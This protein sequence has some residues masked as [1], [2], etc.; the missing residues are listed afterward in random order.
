MTR[1]RIL[2]LLPD[3]NG[4]GAERMMLYLV[5]GLDRSRYE[6][7][8][9][10]GLKRGPYL[11]MVPDDIDFIELGHERG[12]S[13]IGSI[14][15]LFR[16]GGYDLCFSMVSM[17]PAAV[18]ARELSRSRVRLVLGARNHYSSSLPAEA[19]ASRL[20]MLAIRMLYPRAD[21]VIGVSQGVAD[22]LVQNFGVPRS[23]VLAIH[24][25]VDLDR[26][27]ALA[28]EPLD[29]P[30]FAPGARVP[31]LVAVGKLQPAKGYPDLLAAFRRVRDTMPVRLVILG[32]GPDRTQI[33]SIVDRT[34]LRADVRLVGFDVNPY[35]WLSRAA[36]FVHA[37]HWEGFPNVLVEAMA[38][39]TP[40]V[41]TDCPSGPA[42]ILTDGENGFLVPVGDMAAHAARTLAL[43]SDPALRARIRAAADRRVEDFAVARV[44]A[45]YART[46]DDV[47][48]GRPSEPAP[49]TRG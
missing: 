13:S 48:G 36:V 15:R 40:V 34:G 46:F 47:I 9:A 45:R 35:R 38:C 4:G 44:V 29:D 8:L 17:N 30:W 19:S 14:A 21:L 5:G 2:C 24:N 28:T 7:T 31:V 6:I 49:G 1:R 23:R 20:K 41:S 16:S 33:E 11:P 27:R 43:L 12:V 25:P 3:L 42:E 37:A 26:V 32:E 18:V 39:G 10:L 22:D